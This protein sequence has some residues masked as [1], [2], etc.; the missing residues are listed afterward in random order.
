MDSK[1]KA[2]V[3]VAAIVS[4]T[5]IYW[6]IS[7]SSDNSSNDA[8]NAVTDVSEHTEERYRKAVEAETKDPC[9]TPDGYTD[10]A[11]REHMSHHPDRYKECL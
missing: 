4:I 5:L 1:H 8:K 2:M 9:A 10:D 6:S 7:A 11:W 3:F